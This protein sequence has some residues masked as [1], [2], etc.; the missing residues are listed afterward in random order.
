VTVGT[1][2]RVAVAVGLRV[3]VGADLE[4]GVALE[5]LGV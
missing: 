3:L 2:V 1:R 4:V 5:G